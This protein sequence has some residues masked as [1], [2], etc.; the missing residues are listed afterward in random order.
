MDTREFADLERREWADADVARS[1]AN[2]FAKASDMVVPHL[3][4]AVDTGPGQTVLDLCCGHGNVAAGLVASGADVTGLDFSAPMLDLARANVPDARFVEGDAMTLPFAGADF[5]AVTIGFGMPHL[6]DP[7]AALHEARRVLKP[8]GRIA[9]SVW[10]GPEVD[11]VLGYVFDAIA[12]HGDPSIV[13]P[14]GPGA[15]DYADPDTA[16]PA[17]DAAGFTAFT[18]ETVPSRWDVTDPGAP[19]DFFLEGTARGGALLRPQPDGQARAIR[20]A[21]VARVR[22]NHGDGPHWNVPIPAVVISARAI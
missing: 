17:L 6:P 22:A 21:V 16:Y 12:T 13:L 15:N 2:A 11:T 19:Y 4:A 14:P 1:Y 9:F 8:G 10:C 7:P 5:D 18:C 20:A 3:V